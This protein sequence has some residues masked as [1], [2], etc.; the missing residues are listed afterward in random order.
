MINTITQLKLISILHLNR[1]NEA[2]TFGKRIALLCLGI[3]S[4]CI[5][6]A[7]PGEYFKFDGGNDYAYNTAP[8]NIPIGNSSYTIEAWIN[9][10]Y[11]SNNGIIGWG[12]YGVANQ[13]NALKVTNTG[14]TN[15]WWGGGVNDLSVNYTFTAGVWYHVAATYDGST[16]RIYINGALVGS[17][18]P[19]VNSHAVPNANNFKIGS[20][21]A[22]FPEPFNG[23]IDE[24]RIWNTAQS[25]ANIARRRFCELAGNEVGL[26]AYYQFNQGTAG[27][28]NSSITGLINSVNTSNNTCFFSGVTL[29]GSNSNFLAGSPVTSG[30]VVPST[31]P[32][33]PSNQPNVLNT[34]ADLT[35]APSSTVKWYDVAIGGTALASSTILTCGST[36]YAATVNAN[37]CESERVLFKH[38]PMNT[39]LN[40]QVC[41]GASTSA[42]FSSS[43][44]QVFYTW[45][46][47]NPSIGLG[48]SGTGSIPL[49]P[50]TN[51]TGSPLIAN[52]TVTPK[53]AGTPVTEIFN[54]P[55]TEQVWTVPE[56][57]YSVNIE[58]R[59][60]QGAGNT[61]SPISVVK[62]DLAVTPGQLLRIYT[63][64]AGWIAPIGYNGGA[65]G[66]NFGGGASD[67]RVGGNALS[68]RVIV[69]G[70]TGGQNKININED[71]GN[72]TQS[73][74]GAAGSSNYG[75]GNP[76][77]LGIG[78]TSSYGGGGG[79]GY[80]GGGG[81]AGYPN[82][83]NV[84]AGGNGSNYV[85]GVTN[86]VITSVNN[87]GNGSV[88]ITYTPVSQGNPKTFS[89][90]VNPT[91]SVSIT[92]SDADNTICPGSTVIFT[93][94]GVNGGV[95]P[96]Y[97]WN[98]NGN[99]IAGSSGSTFMTSS[100]SNN[101]VI[102]CTYVSNATNCAGTVT[103]NS[104]TTTVL[105]PSPAGISVTSSD[106][107]N[108]IC[109]GTSVTFTATPTNGGSAPTYKWF[110]N[111][112]EIAGETA[113]T[114]TTS[115][116]VN[117]DVISCE[118]TSNSPC[119]FGSSVVTSS[120][121]TTVVNPVLTANATL[122]SSD[123]DN[124]ICSG[125]SVTF[126]I[127][128]T[129]SGSAPTY[130]WYKNG[131]VIPGQTT[132]TYTT[133]SLVNN[134][135]IY[136]EMESNYSCLSGS[137]LVA[138]TGITTAV[139]SMVA[140][141]VLIYSDDQDNIICEG[142]TSVTFT[143]Q[144][145]NEGSSPIFK[146][147]KNGIQLVGETAITYTTTTLANND[148]I[149]CELT[150]NAQC[151]N[152][153]SVVLSP[154]ITVSI[155]PYTSISGYITSADADNV[156]CNGTNV[157]LTANPVGN[158]PFTFQWQQNGANVTMPLGLA[159]Y[160]AFGINN[161]D[162]FTAIITSNYACITGNSSITTAGIT[163]TVTDESVTYST[164]VID[165]TAASYTWTNGTVYTSSGSY[166]QTLVNA[167]GCDSIA[168]LNLTLN[169]IGLNEL[170]NSTIQVYPNPAHDKVNVTFEGTSTISIDLM[171]INGKLIATTPN[172]QSGD[173]LSIENLENGVYMI[174][175]RTEKG[176]AIQRLIKQ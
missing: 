117:N 68:N 114:F 11:L 4:A 168:T 142:G 37:G 116:L 28:N 74:G 46:N 1:K 71:G 158:G 123:A 134:D 39:P 54:I 174:L 143:A 129:A 83:G 62:G 118:L 119:V 12:N 76:G 89:I 59:G 132:T 101:D 45:T 30:S 41:S 163:M 161:G 67:V 157:V 6:F 151:I 79:G 100:L 112:V 90:T 128:P 171:D 58:A 38:I 169:V 57:V 95:T 124:F 20:T 94:T 60:G 18:V 78:G 176:N 86:S 9:P 33:L 131:N 24:V 150:S 87:S 139:S 125:T 31:P 98:L 56:N 152:G 80:Y 15:Y 63:G 53:I 115:S 17:N 122:T 7:Q 69:A 44:P 29:V 42:T 148:V 140:P 8:V 70:G 106:L 51:T 109:E 104:I 91:T 23:G 145:T 3:F 126:T 50:S 153:S 21:N 82:I 13:C 173:A 135:E 149:T 48:S 47:D 73:A 130:I 34:V 156:I 43:C 77:L 108:I 146:W 144:V 64:G 19:T 166:T 102:S 85:G 138:T 120:S 107:D 110:K 164:T 93:A 61:Q 25:E 35:P 133:N 137:A 159:T 36:Y 113:A 92:S 2:L 99:P 103:S 121:I 160:T 5:T 170:S 16:K 27:A 49:F 167:T 175:I 97:T 111:S 66:M 10:T 40:T 165:T 147:F 81:G 65:S 72:G 52:I 154:G 32:I 26:V 127:T 172:V 88:A 55:G 155:I 96:T 162:V 14:I 141:S 75:G 22:S 84:G 136:I 105:T